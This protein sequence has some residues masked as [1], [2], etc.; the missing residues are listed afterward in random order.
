MKTVAAIAALLVATRARADE[1]PTA[2]SLGWPAEATTVEVTTTAHV[3]AAQ[4]SPNSEILHLPTAHHSLWFEN[5]GNYA[6]WTDRI[7]SFL[8]RV[9]PARAVKPAEP[10]IAAQQRPALPLAA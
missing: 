4:L 6:S 5:N 9:A 8:D 1:P 2:A 10:L 7:E 3:R